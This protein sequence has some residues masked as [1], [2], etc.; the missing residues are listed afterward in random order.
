MSKAFT[1]EDDEEPERVGRKRSSSGLP[2][3]AVN[4][5]TG[6]GADLFR[7]ELAELERR[8]KSGKRDERTMERIAQIRELLETATI[9]PTREEVP[10]EVLFETRVT[11]RT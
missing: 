6:R 10:D 8:P 5:L 7:G 9:V 2:P 4:Y 11:V 3:G 1:K